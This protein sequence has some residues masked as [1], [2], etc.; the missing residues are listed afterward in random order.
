MEPKKLYILEYNLGVQATRYAPALAVESQP[1]VE[2]F[3]PFVWFT[4]ESLACCRMRIK[5]WEPS[6]CCV[7]PKKK[8][9]GEIKDGLTRHIF[10]VV[11]NCRIPIFNVIN[12]KMEFFTLKFE[13]TPPF[14][15]I[16]GELKMP[17]F[18]DKIC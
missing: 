9:Y 4:H 5:T 18:S 16:I 8:T 1:F 3:L 15:S 17:V 6:V 12:S 13:K 2:T 14:H 7:W 10:C 11:I